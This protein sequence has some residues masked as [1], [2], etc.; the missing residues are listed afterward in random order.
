MEWETE[1][2]HGHGV[3]GKHAAE[4]HLGDDVKTGLLIHD[5]LNRANRDGKEETNDNTQDIGPSWDTPNADSF[6]HDGCQ[7]RREETLCL[8]V[9]LLKS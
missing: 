9:W 2:H 5:G 7:K 1:Q 6:D 3:A 8:A 4:N